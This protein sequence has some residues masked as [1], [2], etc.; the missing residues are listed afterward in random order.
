ML[1]AAASADGRLVPFCRIDPHHGGLA[2]AQRAVAL[3]AAGI[4]LHPR[5]ERFALGD[6]VVREIV[7]FADDRRVPVIVHAGRGIPSL[8]RDAVELARGFLRA[9]IILA[10]AAITD[11]AWIWREAA[12]QRNLFFDTA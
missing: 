1:G 7:G 5:A 2:E 3:G 4:K 6:P 9:P 10:H 11:L 12:G 8:G